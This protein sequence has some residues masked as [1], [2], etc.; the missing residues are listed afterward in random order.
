MPVLY[1][2]NGKAITTF[3]YDPRAVANGLYYGHE[4]RNDPGLPAEETLQRA[5]EVRDALGSM[6]A[7]RDYTNRQEFKSYVPP[8]DLMR[9]DGAGWRERTWLYP[10]PTEVPYRSV[11]PNQLD[12][13]TIRTIR[14][15]A[16]P[17]T[18]EASN[19]PSGWGI[20]SG[21]DDSRMM[22]N[23]GLLRLLFGD[24][25]GQGIG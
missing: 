3:P 22:G 14:P 8:A 9:E 19:T 24:S 2:R 15:T 20:G 25:A 4:I 18:Q 10:R 1:D 6:W 7:G 12:N 13:P 21:G 5:R 17:L 11:I 23:P 16:P